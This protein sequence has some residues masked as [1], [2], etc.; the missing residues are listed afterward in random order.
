MKIRYGM[1]KYSQ[2]WSGLLV[3]AGLVGL[4]AKEIGILL[5]AAAMSA[6]VAGMIA[7]RRAWEAKKKTAEHP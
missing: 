4:V 6:F 1:P 7:E 5:L 2:V 3:L